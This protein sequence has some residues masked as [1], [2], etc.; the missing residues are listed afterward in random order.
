MLVTKSYP[1]PVLGNG[2][3]IA[4]IFNTAFEVTLSPDKTQIA[5]K[6]DIKNN[7]IE[8]LI[9]L[10]LAQYV[11]QIECRSTFYRRAFC[12]KEKKGVIEIDTQRLREKVSVSFYVCALQAIPDYTPSDCHPD[13]AGLSFP[14]EKAD[15]LADG[16]EGIFIAEKQ[17]DPLNAPV[18]SFMKIQ[19]GNNET[20]PMIVD[21]DDDDII[22]RLSKEDYKSYLKLKD[23]NSTNLHAAVV[24]PALVDILHIVNSD[25]DGVY[26]SYSW[27]ARLKVIC[28]ERKIDISE[29]LEAAQKL[30]GSPVE[31]NFLEQI[32]FFEEE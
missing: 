27:N 30:L 29:P 12:F 18:S 24:F 3:D 9:S 20:G 23:T 8:T 25:K 22:I 16:G 13:Y 15:I 6:I 19:A 4:G 21:P 2:D 14:I 5:Y 26:E 28:R 32:K 11:I 7:T 10:G 1:Y 17:F 31:R